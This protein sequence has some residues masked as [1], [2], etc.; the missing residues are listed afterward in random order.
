MFSGGYQV[1]SHL[2]IKKTKRQSDRLDL[3]ERDAVPN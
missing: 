3:S 2:I 1:S